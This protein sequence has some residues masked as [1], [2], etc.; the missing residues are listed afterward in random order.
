MHYPELRTS[1]LIIYADHFGEPD[2]VN[3]IGEVAY[4][5]QT[6]FV[7]EYC[8]RFEDFLGKKHQI[9]VE[10]QLWKFC[11]GLSDAIWR[12]VEYERP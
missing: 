7:R 5:K 2:T 8:K 10:Q 4:L 6:G 12:F 1:G 9:T 11:V 3:L